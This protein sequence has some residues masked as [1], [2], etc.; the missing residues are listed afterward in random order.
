MANCDHCDSLDAKP[1]TDPWG[2]VYG[3]QCDDCN[4]GVHERQIADYYGGDAPLT[5]R[6]RIEIVHE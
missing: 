5:D 2:K 3:H 1:V 6:E 4:E